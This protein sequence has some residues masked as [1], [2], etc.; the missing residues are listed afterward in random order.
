MILDQISLSGLGIV[1]FSCFTEKPDCLF[2][3]VESTYGSA[4]LQYIIY[5]YSH[6]AIVVYLPFISKLNINL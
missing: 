2:K 3:T 6:P 5:F 1:A 4:I